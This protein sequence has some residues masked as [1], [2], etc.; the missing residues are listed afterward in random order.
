LK[1]TVDTV[2]CTGTTR[3]EH[4]KDELRNERHSPNAQEVR[5]SGLLGDHIVA[6]N[7]WALDL[8]S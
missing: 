3:S 2:L 4:C 1:I 5:L 8:R 7:W 6:A